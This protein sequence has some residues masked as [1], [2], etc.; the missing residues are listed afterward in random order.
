MTTPPKA[1]DPITPRAEPAPATGLANPTIPP[2]T[3]PAAVL[4]DRGD[5]PATILLAAAHFI[6]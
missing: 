4:G 5:L 1:P 3:A 2:A 6:H